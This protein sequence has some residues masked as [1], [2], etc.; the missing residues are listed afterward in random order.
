MFLTERSSS[1][2]FFLS[3]QMQL[4]LA[5][6]DRLQ[7]DAQVIEESF[8]G[9][10]FVEV[11]VEQMRDVFAVDDAVMRNI[12]APASAANVG[13]TSSVLAILSQVVPAGTRSGPQT[14]RG[15]SKAALEG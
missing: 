7:V 4:P 12:L 5:L 13:R 2:W 15:D 6:T 10:G 3:R 9:V 11:A 1:D 8:V 14:D